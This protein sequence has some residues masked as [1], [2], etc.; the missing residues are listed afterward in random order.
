VSLGVS[1]IIPTYNRLSKLKNAINSVLSQTYENFEIIIID[2]NS[3][4][5]TEEY[6][7]SLNNK[8][9]KFYKI[10]NN[11]N[12]AKSR[13]LGIKYSKYKYLAFLDSDDIWSKDKL[14]KCLISI[15]KKNLDFFYHNMELIK[16]N[17][18]W[19]FSALFRKLNPDKLHDDLLYNGPA[20]ATS[21]FIVKK[22]IF[23][24]INNFSEDRKLITWE[25]FDAWLRLSKVTS[26]FGFF[27]ENLGRINIDGTN[28]LQERNKIKNICNFK[29]KYLINYN[30]LPEW[31]L[32]SLLVSF[33]K[34]K[35][36]T[37]VKKIYKSLDL[38]KYNFK[39]KLKIRLIFAISCTLS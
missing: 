22:E 30:N 6:I 20:F 36:Y 12:I 19:K 15:E 1:I 28:S 3:T 38:E 33:F 8:K 27:K 17:F 13:N 24:Q 9:I 2:N 16:K 10:N 34:L 21:S 11:G 25:D 14:R 5:G 7:Y 35:K 31:C 4:D 23:N 18:P 39:N 37:K 29:K 32:L 26:N